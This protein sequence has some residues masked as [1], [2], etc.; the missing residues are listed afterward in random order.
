[1]AGD[2]LVGGPTAAGDLAVPSVSPESPEEAEAVTCETTVTGIELPGSLH[3]SS[4][5][6]KWIAHII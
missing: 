4:G 1:M 2:F 5:V 6:R 3:E